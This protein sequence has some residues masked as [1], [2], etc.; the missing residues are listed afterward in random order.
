LHPCR[1]SKHFLSALGHAGLNKLL[2][3]YEDKTIIAVCTFAYC[4]GPGQEPLLFQGRTYGKLVPARGPLNFGRVGLSA[5][6]VPADS[7]TGWDPCFEYEGE[8][9]A[10]MDKAAKVCR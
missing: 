6:R 4:A 9:Y 7:V 5:M 1:C 3:A 2:A 10:E 8:T